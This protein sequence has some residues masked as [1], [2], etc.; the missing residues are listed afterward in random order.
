[1]DNPPEQIRS[2]IDDVRE[3]LGETLEAIGDRVAPKKVMARAKADAAEK[4]DDVKA[5]LSPRRLVRQG[6]EAARRGVGSAVG[7]DDPR[8]A[9]ARAG[10]VL[11]DAPQAARRR[12][13]GNPVASGLLAF[14][15]G[16]FAA[17]LLPATERERQLTDKAKDR[18]KPL[19]QQAAEVGKS[20]AGE[21]QSSAQE[22]LEAVKGTATEAVEEVKGRAQASTGKVKAEASNATQEV[23]TRTKSATTTVKKQARGSAR[24]V[25]GEAKK[26][27]T[28]TIKRVAAPARPPRPAARP[29][30]AAPRRPR[31]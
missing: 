30:V 25:K 6:V 10:D 3:N 27:P 21:L 17:A 15:G 4:I 24:A 7:G 20:V 23:G 26:E 11:G 8:R 12:A 22:S 13:E 31:P 29:A 14:A 9:Q 1:M 18:L 28:T 19:A 5:R 16:F 2:E